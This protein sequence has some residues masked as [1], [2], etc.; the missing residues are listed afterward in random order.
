MSPQD[1]KHKIWKY[2]FFWKAGDYFRMQQDRSSPRR[3]CQRRIGH[4]LRRGV[5][6]TRSSG[7]RNYGKMPPKMGKCL[8]RIQ[9]WHSGRFEGR[10]FQTGM[11]VQIPLLPDSFHMESEDPLCKQWTSLRSSLA[12]ENVFSEDVK[13][14][15]HHD[16]AHLQSEFDDLIMHHW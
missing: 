13:G 8:L 5:E 14:V 16:K 9:P 2:S 7:T 11:V 6:R 3:I 4:E 10:R 12:R 1:I 15:A